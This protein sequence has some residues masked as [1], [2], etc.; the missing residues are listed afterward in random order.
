M[1]RSLVQLHRQSKLILS[2]TIHYNI[3]LESN[4]NLCA[5]GKHVF[6]ISISLNFDFGSD[7][8]LLPVASGVTSIST[9]QSL[10]PIN[11]FCSTFKVFFWSGTCLVQ[12]FQLD[13]P[14][15]TAREE[16]RARRTN[17]VSYS[18]VPR[19]SCVE[20]G[21]LTIWPHTQGLYNR[22]YNL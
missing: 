20:L 4:I 18:Q 8:C 13:F 15:V 11:L 14:D 16:R 10:A 17:Q 7:D 21:N 12:I 9:A 3:K 5:P 1:F 2:K 19:P 6:G 22:I